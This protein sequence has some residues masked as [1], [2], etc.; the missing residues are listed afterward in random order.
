[1]AYPEATP[2]DPASPLT[3]VLLPRWPAGRKGAFD[4]HRSSTYS[5][6]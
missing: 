5:I 3:G 6:T 1:M 4:P 2:T